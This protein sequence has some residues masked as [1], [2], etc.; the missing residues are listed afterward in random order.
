VSVKK[1]AEY[2]RKLNFTY[3][4]HQ[5]IGFYLEHA[6]TYK[7]ADIKLMQRFPIEY[8]FYLNYQLKNPAH[9]EKWRLF[10]PQ[11]F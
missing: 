6:G 4:Y 8:D 10:T 5:A 3:P 9:N 7:A 11:R 1:L 2:L